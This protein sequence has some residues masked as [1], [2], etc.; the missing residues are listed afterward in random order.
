VHGKSRGRLLPKRKAILANELFGCYFAKRLKRS[1]LPEPTLRLTMGGLDVHCRGKQSKTTETGNLIHYCNSG[2][3]F[4]PK[5]A[6]IPM[7]TD[8]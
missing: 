6:A 5:V 1:V 7:T 8:S 4:S 3:Y 2:L